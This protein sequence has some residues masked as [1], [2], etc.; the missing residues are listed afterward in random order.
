MTDAADAWRELARRASESKFSGIRSDSN[1]LLD[2]ADL[3]EGTM[4]PGGAANTNADAGGGMMPPMMMGGMG[5]GGGQAAPSSL[6]GGGGAMPAGGAAPSGP[7]SPR[8]GGGLPSATELKPAD[9]GGMPAGGAA[10]S[11]RIPGGDIPAGGAPAD[12]PH[13]EEP[14][15]SEEAAEDATDDTS[16]E[17]EETSEEMPP[18]S[19]P[20]G[21]D[22]GEP[23]D[24]ER[25]GVAVEEEQLAEVAQLWGELSEAYDGL[26]ASMPAPTSLGFLEDA[27][28]ASDE[29]ASVTQRWGMEAGKEFLSIS[30]QLLNAARSYDEAET[31][32]VA[33]ARPA[34][35]LQ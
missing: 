26:A 7:Y 9:G 30:H 28:L 25:D 13:A 15:A 10:P 24:I 21:E 19:G 17:P 27:R 32:A 35:E 34:G 23:D 29:F 5:G 3:R 8:A 18:Q 14:P 12:E 22:D 16:T 31:A 1:D 2:A 6:G 20:G 11:G 33:M 4:A